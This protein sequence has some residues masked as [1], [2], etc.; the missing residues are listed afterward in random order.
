VRVRGVFART[1]A[2]LGLALAASA[3]AENAQHLNSHYLDRFATRKPTLT[4]FTVCHGFGCAERSQATLS[5][6]EWG[7]VRAAF[8]PR[9]RDARTER[10]QIAQ[11]VALMERLVGPQTGTGVHQW[12]HRNM[13]V[14]PNRGDTTQLDCVDESVNTWTYMTMMEGGNLLRFHRVAELSSA[15]G[16][17]DP[18]MRNTAVLQEK[19]GGYYAVDASLVDYAEPPVVMPLAT[20]MGSWPPK[21]V[22]RSARRASDSGNSARTRLSARN[23]T[24]L[25]D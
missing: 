12:T 5:L 8:R 14:L 4:H 1:L 21:A 11:A 15:G 3:C 13:L 18:F 16:L 9:A 23:R 6:A 19:G 10:R 2:A 24:D 22:A 17:T 25:S 7:K 20:W